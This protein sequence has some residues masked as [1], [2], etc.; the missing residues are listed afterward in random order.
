[1]LTHKQKWRRLK[2]KKYL[3]NEKIKTEIKKCVT[4]SEHVIL[5]YYY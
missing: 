3:N 1:M 2:I 5:Y 4:F